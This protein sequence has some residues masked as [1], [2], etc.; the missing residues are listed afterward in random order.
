MEDKEVLASVEEA[1]TIIRKG[2][3]LILVDD[4]DRENEG[5]FTFASEFVSPEKINFVTKYGRGLVCCAI[6]S[7]IANRLQ[8]YPMVQ[9][10]TTKYG[11]AFTVSIDAKDG[12]TTGISAYDRD[13][14]VKKII[15]ENSGPEDFVKPGHIFPIVAKD[16]GVIVRAGHTEGSTDLCRLAGLKTSAVICE[17]IREDGHMARLPDLI[18]IA[19]KFNLKITSIEDIIR[20]RLK[21]ECNV[22]KNV[23]ARLPTEHGEFKIQV[24][25]NILDGSQNVALVMGELGKDSEPCLVRVHS[26][27]ITGDIF[28]SLRCDCGEQLKKSMEM[29]GKEGRGVIVYIRKESMEK[30]HEGRGIGLEKKLLTYNLQDSGF[31]TVEANLKLG[32]PPDLRDYGIGAQILRCIGVKKMRLLTNN[33]RKVV[34][35]SGYNLEI[36]E[37]VPIQTKP[38]KENIKYLKTKKEKLGHTIKL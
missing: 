6:T 13:I 17:I 9:N 31:D 23:E 8:L 3:I 24:W 14:T 36:T 37:I 27:C 1:I 26:E 12:T 7:D 25:E 30:S 22:R 10:N 20:H 16:G 32:Y 38:N 11:T 29:I 18:Q 5:D 28:G 33:P 35:L 4:M 2:G 19:K 34:G 15:D 21:T